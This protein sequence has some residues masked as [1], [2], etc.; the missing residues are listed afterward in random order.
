MLIDEGHILH[1][2]PDN[3]VPSLHLQPAVFDDPLQHGE[4]HDDIEE[5]GDAHPDA[6]LGSGNLDSD[7]EYIN[8]DFKSTCSSTIASSHS[9]RHLYH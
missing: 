8:Q 7:S 2:K 4:G 3:Y 6:A 1:N 9:S 5:M